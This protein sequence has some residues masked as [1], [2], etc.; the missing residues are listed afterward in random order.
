MQNG[1]TK[2]TTVVRAYAKVAIKAHAATNCLTEI[3][4]V[5]AERAVVDGEVNLK[6]PLAG[7]PVSLKDSVCVKGVDTTVGYSSGVGT[8]EEENGVLVRCLKE[9]GMYGDPKGE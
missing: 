8:A 2:A 4:F 6:G 7:V 5:D 9:A 3:L 1:T